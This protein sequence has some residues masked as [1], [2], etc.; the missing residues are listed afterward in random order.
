MNSTANEFGNGLY[1][2]AA[3][4]EDFLVCC[5][6]TR[7]CGLENFKDKF[8]KRGFNFGIAEQNLLNVA[9]GIA[10][11]GTKAYVATFAVF[12]TMRA[13]EQIRQFIAYPCQDVTLLSTHTGL[14]VGLDGGTHIAVED[15]GIMR[16]LPNMT[17]L[18]PA[19]I[20]AAREM[21]KFSLDFHKPLYIRLHRAPVE[22]VYDASYRF[23]FNKARI[24]KEYGSEVAILS[25]GVM[26]GTALKAAELLAQQG[27]GATVADV[28]TIKPIDTETIVS[29]AKKTGRIVTL[30][31][32]NIIGGLGSAAAE[33]LSRHCPTRMRMLGIP[34][35]YGESGKPEE[36]YR[37][38]NLHPAGVAASVAAFLKEE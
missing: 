35:V 3:E 14:Q 29:L 32:H 4:R 23:E 2:A 34:D 37:L 9:A 24:V 25:T 8:P 36:L 19:D 33:E 31:D 5:P 22:P 18:Q 17:I 16:T 13:C 20:Y 30:E 10:S 26:V 21:V 28:S 27:I 15:V 11:T 6:D 7:S 12:M 38:H 1:E